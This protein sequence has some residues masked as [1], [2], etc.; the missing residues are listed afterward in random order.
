MHCATDEL[1]KLCGISAGQIIKIRTC[2]DSFSGT[3]FEDQ[4]VNPNFVYPEVEGADSDVI[5]LVDLQQ[6]SKT[7][8]I[9]DQHCVSRQ[10][11]VNN[12]LES[13]TASHVKPMPAFNMN[14]Q[15]PNDKWLGTFELP[16]Q[17]SPSVTESLQKG[18]LPGKI[19]NEFT[20]DICSAVTVYT[21]NPTKHQRLHVAFMITKAYPFL[22]DKIGSG[23]ASWEQAIKHRFKNMRKHKITSNP[24]SRNQSEEQSTK[25][26]RISVDTTHG[27]TDETIKEHITTIKKE[28]GKSSNKNLMLVK[29]L[30]N[31]TYGSRQNNIL[32]NPVSI[33]ETLKMFPA[34]KLV[35]EAV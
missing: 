17:F 7:S 13:E 34:L 3:D 18:Y 15:I 22:A 26:R 24:S 11:A 10:D 25:Q 28:M 29:E 2:I 33:K 19:R 16:T 31:V 5:N 27:E 9:E 35:T 6:V 1:L 23:T 8:V 32:S 21:M 12:H 20:R 30:M 4:A 14:V